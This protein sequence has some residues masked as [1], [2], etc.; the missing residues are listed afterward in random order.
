MAAPNA[1]PTPAEIRSL[2]M[3][4][5]RLLGASLVEANLVTVDQLESANERLLELIGEGVPRQC[6]LLGVLAY[7]LKIVKEEDVLQHCVDEHNIG[8]IDLRTYDGA[9][10][11]KAG[12]NLPACWATWTV[13]FDRED[14]FVLLATAYH[15]S[16]A[17]RTY[18]E[19]QYGGNVIWYGTTLEEIAE[20]LERLAAVAAASGKS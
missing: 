4:A 16:P 12:L 17:V 8:L 7:D 5:N 1:T 20:T 9:E 10:D 6:T 13:P 19:K 2:L 3:R 14:D 15:L 18:W 11:V